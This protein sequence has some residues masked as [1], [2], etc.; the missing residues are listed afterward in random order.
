VTSQQHASL[1]ASQQIEY[2]SESPEKEEVFSYRTIFNQYYQEA[3]SNYPEHFAENC[4]LDQFI[5]AYYKQN[6][7]IDAKNWTN[8]SDLVSNKLSAG[9]SIT[10]NIT[11]NWFATSVAFSYI[12]NNNHRYITYA[13]N[14][15]KTKLTMT[16]L[17]NRI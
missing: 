3:K 12:G 16:V 4:S 13:S 17:Y 15:D 2:R 5:S 7:P 1:K 14:L 9:S 10:V 11:Q 6:L 8:L